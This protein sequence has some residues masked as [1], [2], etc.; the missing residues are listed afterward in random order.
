MPSSLASKRPSSHIHDGAETL[1][2]FQTRSP[3]VA[4]TMK[5]RT[6]PTGALGSSHKLLAP[7]R[8]AGVDHK[9]SATA[10]PPCSHLAESNL[11]M[12]MITDELLT[13][14]A[15]ANELAYSNCE[16]RS[17]LRLRVGHVREAPLA[18]SGRRGDRRR[19]VLLQAAEAVVDLCRRTSEDLTTTIRVVAAAGTDPRPLQPAVDHHHTPRHRHAA[20]HQVAGGVQRGRIALSA[21]LL[22]R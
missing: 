10:A 2:R 16:P 22:R 11:V 15:G 12:V 21:R 13:S 14:S 4:S 5:G 19:V 6:A 20:S 3:G 1:S 8:R 9:P 18:A 17:C 7:T